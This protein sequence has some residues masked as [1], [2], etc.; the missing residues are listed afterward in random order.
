M[1]IALT[2]RHYPALPLTHA[3]DVTL[4]TGPATSYHLVL[5]VVT[6]LEIERPV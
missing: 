6:V 4:R 5:S 3:N 2:T 1:L